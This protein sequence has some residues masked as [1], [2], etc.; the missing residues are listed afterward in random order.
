MTKWQRKEKLGQILT[1][2]QN[3]SSAQ[4][5]YE[6]TVLFNF[7]FISLLVKFSPQLAFANT[8]MEICYPSNHVLP[9]NQ[10]NRRQQQ[11]SRVF[12]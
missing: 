4:A 8:Q 12:Q 9:I 2:L 7:T 11:K 6:N 1:I 10:K 3:Q 5:Y